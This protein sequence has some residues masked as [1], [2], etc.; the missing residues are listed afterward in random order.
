MV[1]P[2]FPGAVG[3][4]TGFWRSLKCPIR[5]GLSEVIVF[6]SM[7]VELFEFHCSSV[8]SPQFFTVR[9]GRRGPD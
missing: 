7:M 1:P 5:I 4:N 2:G 3:M 8:T 9:L 6:G